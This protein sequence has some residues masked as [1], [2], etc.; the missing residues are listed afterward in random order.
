MKE[1]LFKIRINVQQEKEI[2]RLKKR[3]A[4][5]IVPRKKNNGLTA[6][7]DVELKSLRKDYNSLTNAV[8]KQNQVLKTEVNTLGRVNAELA[9]ERQRIKAVVIGLNEFDSVAARI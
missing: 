4:E 5:L 1:V 7:E 8:I 9:I 6:K 3:I 2:D